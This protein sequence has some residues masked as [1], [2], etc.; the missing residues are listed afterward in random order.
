MAPQLGIW[1]ILLYH[2]QTGFAEARQELWDVMEEQ[3]PLEVPEM[4]VDIVVFD[5]QKHPLDVSP[6]VLPQSFVCPAYC[7]PWPDGTPL[8]KHP[9]SYSAGS[10]LPM[11]FRS[12]PQLVN[13]EVMVLEGGVFNDATVFGFQKHPLDMLFA[14]FPQSFVCP[15]YTQF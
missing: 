11:S 10:F 1:H 12:P 8:P 6:A 2:S 5:F 13:G 15:A 9:T 4:P 7:Q 14:M 3:E